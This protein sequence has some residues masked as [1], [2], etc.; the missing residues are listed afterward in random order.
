MAM[1]RRQF[2]KRTGACAAGSFLAP[3]FFRNP[4]LL[5]ALADTIGDRYFVVLFLDGGN[6]GL[7]TVVPAD[8][9]AGLRTAYDAA[10]NTGSGGLR[11]AA[12][13]LLTAPNMIDPNSGT[14]LGLHP[15]LSGLKHLYDLG[16][17]AVIQGCG[18]PRYDLSHDVSSRIWETADPLGANGFG[19]GWMGRYLA[20][21]YTS[22]QIPA[23]SIR[24]AVAGELFTNAT[25]ILAIRRLKDFGFPYDSE[26]GGDVAAKRAA[27]LDLHLEASASD[28]GTM[29]Y[30][31]DG[32]QATLLS[33]ESYPQLHYDYTQDPLLKRTAFNDQYNALSSSTARGLR[34]IAK[35]IY[36]VE[37][38]VPNVHARF[39]ELANGGY[40]T[41]SDQGGA[42]ADGQHYLLHQEVGDAL[43]VFYD[44][45]A[46]MGVIDKLCVMIWSEFSRRI[47]QNDNGT[48]HGSQGP[49]FVIGGKVN[50]GV[51]GNH[52]NIADLDGEG[53]TRYSQDGGD[54]FRSTD[55]R[56]VYGTILKH[57]LNMP[58]AQIFSAVLPPDS[59]PPGQANRYWTNP[60]FDLAKDAGATPLFQP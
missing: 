9:A 53:N 29:S 32:G 39:F 22:T 37:R 36:G 44:D 52:P 1:T 56:D 43:K 5:K 10:R 7:N 59:A 57:W 51:Y 8:N 34:E 12:S 13:T 31:G 47:V 28:L 33:S 40:D 49:M 20:A 45:C 21:N 3:S 15:G 27:F 50:G 48:D 30:I 55:F 38:G 4:S 11:L 17:V 46:D 14:Q 16:R 35:I 24:D 41:H 2:L 58:A 18:Y 42:N 25:S 54:D 6:D 19:S 26:Y 60:N 23:V